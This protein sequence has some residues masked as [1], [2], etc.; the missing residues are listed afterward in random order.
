MSL[1]I[2]VYQVDDKA[3]KSGYV[4]QRWAEYAT[5]AATAASVATSSGATPGDRLRV[6]Q[7]LAFVF[8]A[9]AAQ[10]AGTTYLVTIVGA[11]GETRFQT[12]TTFTA[13]AVVA[14]TFNALL[15]WLILPGET[16][17]VTCAFSAGA[18]SNQVELRL[19]GYELPR[20][21]VI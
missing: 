8:T 13:A 16:V 15:E 7:A 11:N 18:N 9:G 20:G 2:P 21:N 14:T 5:N 4:L 12:S 19:L 10:T 17:R 1:L 6:L 3:A